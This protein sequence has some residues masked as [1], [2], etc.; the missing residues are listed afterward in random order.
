MKHI[1]YPEFLISRYVCD[2]SLTE[3]VRL[4]KVGYDTLAR[5]AMRQSQQPPLRFYNRYHRDKRSAMGKKKRDG[6]VA[7]DVI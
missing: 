3:K 7:D 1:A 2:I 4:A 5:Y 6:S